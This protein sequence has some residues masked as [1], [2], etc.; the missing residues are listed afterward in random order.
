MRIAIF[1]DFFDSIG[2]GEKLVVEMARAL[3]ADIITNNL[4]KET[5][6]KMGCEDIKFINLGETIKIPPLKQAQATR[7]FSRV[8]FSKNYD[9]FILSGNW[10]PFAAKKH[11][12]NL[13]YCN[14]PTRVF[15][16]L[17]GF[18]RS[19][20]NWY[21]KLI[22]PIYVKYQKF[23][24]KKNVPHLNKILANSVN[25]QKRIKKYWGVDSSVVYCAV[26]TKKFYCNKS[27]SYWLSVNRIY[28]AKRIELQLKAF[29]KLPNE[30]L[31]IVGGI[32]NGDGS[33]GY[34]NKMEKISPLNVKFLGKISENNLIDLYS[35]CKGFITTSLNEDFGLTPIEA[36]A[37]GKP[38]IAPNEGGYKETII[39]GKTGILIDNINVDKLVETIKKMGKEMEKN[40]LKYKNACMKQAKKFDTKIFVDKIKGFI[41]DVKNG[42]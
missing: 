35:N 7:R 36:M 6:R 41:N 39:N 29:E 37:S 42:K 27:G 25:I 18:Y 24:D 15:Y 8:D 26:D 3:N 19:S 1:Q 5:I 28:S 13:Y 9:F 40:P 4:N 17:Y 32:A 31:I 14:T 33:E 21:G 23:K 20:F 11:K 22:F 12:P 30:K 10:G 2:G 38:V 34:K 16:D